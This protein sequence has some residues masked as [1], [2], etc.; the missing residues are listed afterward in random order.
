MILIIIL[1]IIIVVLYFYQS[2]KY[3][4]EEN[5]EDNDIIK[6]EFIETNF[7]KDKPFINPFFYEAQFHND[8]RDTITKFNDIVGN[9]KE[10]F[11]IQN[12]PYS[13]KKASK[14][15]IKP[16][17]HK[18]IETLNSTCIENRHNWKDIMPD[19]N[20]KSGYEKSMEDLGVVPVLYNYPAENDFI[21]LI[22]IDKS[23]KLETANEIRLTTYVILQKNNVDDQLII[24]I[25]F[26]V[27]NNDYNLNRDFFKNNKKF[28]VQVK[29]EEIFVI[30]FLSKNNF[31]AKAPREKYY[32]MKKIDNGEMFCQEEIIKQLV[33]K[34]REFAK[35]IC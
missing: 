26:Y 19:K 25:N 16:F 24:K 33:K 31:G 10:L 34:K 12:L 17:I 28:D 21:K 27:D 14:K 1:I 4:Y 3:K 18:F 22:K 20:M 35:I 32:D 23:Q 8:Y 29:I 30:G 15:E 7:V 11:N 9:Q 2:Q 5:C 13:V 6:N